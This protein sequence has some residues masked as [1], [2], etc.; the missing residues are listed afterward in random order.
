ML[1]LWRTKA[2]CDGTR[3]LRMGPKCGRPLGLGFNHRTSELY[4][5]DAYYGLCKVGVEGGLATQVAINAQGLPL[6][7]TDGIDV[8][9]TTQIVYFTDVSTKYSMM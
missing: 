5:A 3:D 4:I 1:V 7:W 2:V 9:Q 6:K 8:D